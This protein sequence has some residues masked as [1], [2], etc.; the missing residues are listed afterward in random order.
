MWARPADVESVYESIV[1]SFAVK[2]FH[3]PQLRHIDVL[4]NRCDRPGDRVPSDETVRCFV[5]IFESEGD[6]VVNGGDD[7][8]SDEDSS[9]H[10]DTDD[11]D[12]D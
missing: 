11:E 6:I 1:T 5:S 12:F 2:H 10:D 7:Q 9:D 8:S 4:Q 3:C